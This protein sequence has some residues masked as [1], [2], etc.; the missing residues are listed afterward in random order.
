MTSRASPRSRSA[1]L[2][3]KRSRAPRRR[4]HSRARSR[5]TL[6]TPTPPAVPATTH[7]APA[8]PHRRPASAIR[9]TRRA[10]STGRLTCPPSPTRT[11]GAPG[12]TGAPGEARTNEA[13]AGFDDTR[14]PASSTA[15]RAY[16][17]SG[18]VRPTR[19]TRLGSSVSWV[20]MQ[21][22][23]ASSTPPVHTQARP[24]GQHGPKMPPCAQKGSD[25]GPLWIEPT[26][27]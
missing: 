9:E 18:G 22:R 25:G 2:R 7:T 17:R 19:A 4:P 24:C 13:C 16:S 26:L 5:T 14:A 21:P 15:S 20:V 10:V 8:L 23:C 6:V 12:G 11:H 27:E 1:R 3:H